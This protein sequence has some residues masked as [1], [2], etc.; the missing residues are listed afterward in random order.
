M[1]K[2][3]TDTSNTE[4]IK[5][6]D[7]NKE[8]NPRTRKKAEKDNTEVNDKVETVRPSFDK[9]DIRVLD[10]ALS[11]KQMEEWNSIYASYRSN[12]LLK[13]TV[14]GVDKLYLN[15]KNPETQE[16]EQKTINCLVILDYRV[17]VMIPE[18]EIWFNKEIRYNPRILQQMLGA[19]IDYV[20]RDIDREGEFALASRRMAL[21]RK[22]KIFKRKLHPMTG[23]M[24]E[25]TILAVS[26]NRMLVNCYGYDIT[27]LPRDITYGSVLDLR[28]D[29]RP[30]GNSL[31]VFK[32][33]DG[34]QDILKIS[35]KEVD[36]HPFIGVENR[37]PINCRRSS[38]I[39]GK[40]KG[41]VFCELEKDLTCLC[42]YSPEQEDKHFELGD[43]VIIII[44]KYDYAKKLV[45]GRIISRW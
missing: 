13:G 34:E 12:S 37:H 16:M 21:E 38:R 3:K 40:Y 17:K 28:E 11:P 7:Q 24:L 18:S 19:T 23:D 43:K 25:C 10:R 45:Y 31:C 8:N 32:E 39:T 15:I 44:K 22:R 30:G 5:D 6:V 26:T 42:L 9:L 33:Y 36:P 20:I 35:I 14:V 2:E 27:L 29:Y 1:K 4:G 41:G